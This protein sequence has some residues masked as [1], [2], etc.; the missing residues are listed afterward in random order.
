MNKFIWVFVIV[1]AGCASGH[2]PTP[3][4]IQAHSTDV[5]RWYENRVNELKAS[6]G[7]LN[8][9]GL[10]WLQDG[11]NSFGS[12]STNDVVFPSQLPAKA[13]YYL[14]KSGIVSLVP[15]KGVDVSVNGA[16]IQGPTTIFHPDSTRAIKLLEGSTVRYGS[17]EWYVIKRD[18]RLGL[19]VRDLESEAVKSFGGI[20]RYPVDIHWK[21][22]ASFKAATEGKTID[23][24]NVLGQTTP[25][26]LAGTYRFMLGAR[27]YTLAATGTGKKL[28]VVFGDP[29]NG[30]E[31]YGAGRFIYIDRPDSLGNVWIDFNKAY[32]PPCVFTEFATCPLP[33]KE[34]V[35]TVPIT[36]GEK[37]Y[38]PFDQENEKE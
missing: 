26:P 27:E 32:N 7:W 20:E 6:D 4:E 30:K 18:D 33:A 25:V 19:R 10:F 5:E 13:G 36:A 2:K 17:L 22:A 3:A 31:T 35:L 16:S 28:F 14:V 9:V 37:N 29:T 11:I 21:V 34:N 12:D 24:T 23:I 38:H 8:L 1:F 15:N